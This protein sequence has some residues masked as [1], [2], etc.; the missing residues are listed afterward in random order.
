MSLVLGTGVRAHSSTTFKASEVH[1][2]PCSSD[3]LRPKP[4]LDQLKFGVTPTDH[5]LEIDWC[6]E[7]GWSRPVI[8][9]YGPLFL[10]PAAKVLHYGCSL[11]EGM[12]CYRSVDGRL[13]LFRPDRN[14]ARMQR[15]A[16]RSALPA[17]AAG[18]LMAL[19]EKLIRMDAEWVPNDPT[20][21]LYIRPNMF[22]TDARLGVEVP[23][24]AKLVVMLS[25]T[26]PYFKAGY[27][28]VKLDANPHTVRAWEGGSGQYKI[29]G[30]YGP[31][32]SI[33]EESARMHGCD[34]NLW[35]YG[36]ER[37][38]T[39]VGAMNIMFVVRKEGGGMELLT[40]PLNS[41]ILPGV[42]RESLLELARQWKE[43]EVTERVISM[44]ELEEWVGSGRLLEMFGCGTAAVVS[45]VG[46][47]VYEGKEIAIPQMSREESIS[48][49][50]HKAITDIQYGRVRHE[51]SVEIEGA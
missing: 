27:K 50:F 40:P 19:I 43:F 35:L 5:L 13:L 33:Q 2:T 25:P 9:P 28:P 48:Q 8:R 15:S 6:K 31:T 11:F 18:E 45:P 14:M 3:Q 51:W 20:S 36:P 26:G 41:L 17:F 37:Q 22:G 7:E 42:T 12:K 29:A 34:Q 47:V 30:N 49:R 39:E 44:G 4:P 10:D 16:Q 21:S 38:I 46:C 1:I 24:K 32:L 23:Q